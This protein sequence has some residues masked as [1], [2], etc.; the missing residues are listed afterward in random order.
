M[1]EEE[2][3]SEE[4][5][6]K[7]RRKRKTPLK[8]ETASSWRSDGGEP[9]EDVEDGALSHETRLS[10]CNNSLPRHVCPVCGD[11]ANGLHYG[12]YSCEGCKNFFKRSIVA[13]QERPY[14]CKF[15][16]ECDISVFDPDG[17]KRNRLRCQACRYSA[18]LDAGMHHHSG[19]GGSLMPRLG[20]PRKLSSS[21]RQ[22]ETEDTPPMEDNFEE[23]ASHLE[24]RDLRLQVDLLLSKNRELSQSLKEK[25]MQL[26]ISEKQI[27][28]LKSQI[29]RLKDRRLNNNSSPPNANGGRRSGSLFKD[30]NVTITPILPGKKSLSPPFKEERMEDDEGE[31]D[32]ATIEAVSSTNNAQQPATTIKKWKINSYN[33]GGDN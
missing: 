20:R 15:N 21:H 17:I 16:N 3:T 28:N 1:E 11:R 33:I 10:S 2:S 29:T 9:E 14:F 18:C 25:E 4:S 8:V 27:S 12:I 6:K 19:G 26:A 24:A 32:M 30:G 22:F 23:T 7:N 5:K 13:I 31:E